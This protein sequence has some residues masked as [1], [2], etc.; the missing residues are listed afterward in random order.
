MAKN[1]EIFLIQRIE[2]KVPGENNGQTKEHFY[3]KA[4]KKQKIQ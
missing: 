4:E 1:V 3:A 2:S